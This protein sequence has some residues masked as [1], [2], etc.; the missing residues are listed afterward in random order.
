MAEKIKIT[1][2][3]ND[4][5]P[6]NEIE[7]FQDQLKT[8]DDSELEKLKQ[9]ILKYGFS[10][11]LFIWQNKLLDGHQ[12]LTAV[13]N[14]INNDDIEI[15]GGKLPVVFIDAE[16]E[17]EAAE[18]LLLINSRYAKITQNGFESFVERYNVN[19]P[20]FSG[21]LVIPEIEIN[22]PQI[23]F[24]DEDPEEWIEKTDLVYKVQ[25][26][27]ENEEQQ[28]QLVQQLEEMGIQ[29]QPLIL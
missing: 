25:I 6:I 3:T 1:C 10:F 7:N 18:K 9:S 15:D 19:L 8:I 21:L 5:L 26:D 13:K 27:C 14:L 11:P 28:I 2:R 16:D 12:R 22:I 23:D 4:Y 20:D 29:C 17:K 24:P